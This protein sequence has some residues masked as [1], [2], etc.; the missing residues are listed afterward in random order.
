M[1]RDHCNAVLDMVEVMP[2]NLFN[3]FSFSS[4]SSPFGEET[5]IVP[6]SNDSYG[7][8]LLH[9][10][11]DYLSVAYNSIDDERAIQTRYMDELVWAT[12]EMRAYARVYTSSLPI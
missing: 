3:E 8:F 12:A 11:R 4:T 1:Q 2:L 6:V 7:L 10:R 5:V 9:S